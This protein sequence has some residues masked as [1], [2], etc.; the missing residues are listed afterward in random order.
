MKT[1]TK[2]CSSWERMRIRE[3]LKA[4]AHRR[5]VP[6]LLFTQC[7][8]EFFL[9]D[10]AGLTLSEPFDYHAE[11]SR[12]CQ[13]IATVVSWKY[14]ELE[15]DTSIGFAHDGLHIRTQSEVYIVETTI[16][17]AQPYNIRSAGMT[18]WR[19]KSN[20]NTDNISF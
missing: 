14:E 3:V 19:A 1:M 13:I 18:V 6:S 7:T 20:R 8:M 4:Q 5:F 17:V 16:P 15:F 10:R 11:A 12:F 2:P 9:W